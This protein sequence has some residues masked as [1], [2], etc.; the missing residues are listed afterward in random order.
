MYIFFF[1]S[2]VDLNI[3]RKDEVLYISVIHISS[4][5]PSH[6]LKNARTIVHLSVFFK[7]I[8]FYKDKFIEKCNLMLLL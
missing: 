2:K 6:A 1:Y 3:M 8:H 7:Q 4:S 5:Q